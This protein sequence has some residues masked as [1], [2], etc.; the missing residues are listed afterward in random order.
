MLKKEIKAKIISDSYVCNAGFWTTDYYV[1]AEGKE[2]FD[3]IKKE[4]NGK[5]VKITIQEIEE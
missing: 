2:D 5:K 1:E 4:F 3:D